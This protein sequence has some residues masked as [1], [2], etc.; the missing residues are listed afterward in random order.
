V[1]CTADVQVQVGS[2]QSCQLNKPGNTIS[3]IE[4]LKPSRRCCAHMWHL[5]VSALPIVPQ[6][7]GH[8]QH[9]G[10]IFDFY[11][12]EL[13]HNVDC[14]QSCCYLVASSM[15]GRNGVENF[16][17]LFHVDFYILHYVARVKSALAHLD[18]IQLAR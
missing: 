2:L 10:H 11:L 4:S 3:T 1:G 12:F 16:L 17:I 8:Y 9:F 6:V 15:L 18:L 14:V 7:L 5:L 13:T